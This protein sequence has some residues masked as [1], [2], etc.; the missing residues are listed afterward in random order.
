LG[1]LQPM[2]PLK[3]QPRIQN[4]TMLTNT[5]FETLVHSASLA[6]SADNMQAWAFAKNDNE[7]LVRY[8]PERALP[9]DCNNMF[10]WLG[11]GAAIQ[12]MVEAS[13]ACG[14]EMSV[15][16]KVSDYNQWAATLKLKSAPVTENL[17]EY[18]PLRRTNRVPYKIE[19]L[20]QTAVQAF[21]RTADEF[22]TGLGLTQKPSDFRQLASL[23]ADSSY[24][25][26]EYQPFHDELFEILR[27]T[28]NEIE[29][30]RYGLTFESL[31]VPAFAV[32]FAMLMQY[33]AVN[34]LVNR[35][36]V[37]RLVARQLSQKINASGAILLLYVAEPN[38]KNY[39]EAG[40]AMEKIW[41]QA[42]KFGLSVQPY[43]VLPQYFT[44][45]ELEPETLLPRYI[46]KL[47]RQRTVFN[48][49]FPAA[50]EHFP[51]MVL[52]IGE[53]NRHSLRN[54]IRLHPEQIIEQNSLYEL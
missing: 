11:I 5:L 16:Y 27:F 53:A 29:T 54:G 39:I 3:Q 38:P 30:Y 51:A 28:R 21:K 33:G 14:F 42:V 18:I 48:E 26:L 4:R 52:R 23:D 46:G 47:K 12:N 15:S 41:L 24:I 40:R 32:R 10:G 1:K 20:P 37:S 36:G 9:T 6:P 34:R 8:P 19:P 7:I 17:A 31:E 44:K 2:H 13:K 35:L 25:R 43:G 22:S 49:L 45:I 50:R